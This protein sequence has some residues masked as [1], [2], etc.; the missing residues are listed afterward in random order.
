MLK[1]DA[2]S[3]MPLFQQ[4]YCQIRADI[5]S[6][7]RAEGTRLPSLRAMSKEMQVGKNTVES[8]YAQLAL[9]AI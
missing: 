1:L 2:T 9:K 7:T 5:L 6:G 4:I 3:A 8:A